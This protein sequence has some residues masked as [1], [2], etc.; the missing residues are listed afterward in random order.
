M[1][2]NAND[3]TGTTLQW[4][5]L[6]LLAGLWVDFVRVFSLEW[7]INEQYAYGYLVP[8]LCLYLLW[9]RWEKQPAVRTVSLRWLWLTLC[10]VAFI[11]LIPVR[12]V[13]EANPDWRLVLWLYAV[14]VFSLSLALLLMWGGW[15]WMLHFAPALALMLFAVPW[16]VNLEER[17]VLGL[18]HGVATVTVEAMNL[19]GIYAEQSGNLIR[20]SSGL[21]G[22]EEACSGVR[23][24]QSTLMAGY[25]LG[26][27]LRFSLGWRTALLLMGACVS[28]VLNIG[29]TFALTY[30]THQR[31]P[32]YMESVH[33]SVGHVVSL[34]AFV[35]LLILAL[36]IKK[37]LHDE[38]ED[39]ATLQ[40]ANPLP[41]LRWLKMPLISTGICL[42]VGGLALNIAWYAIKEPTKSQRL[43]ATVDWEQAGAEMEFEE[44]SPAIRAALR[45][46]EGV[47]SV[48]ET[49]VKEDWIVYFFRW[50]GG[51]ISSFAGVHRPETCL[52]AAGFSPGKIG[53]PLIFQ[54][55]GLEVKFHSQ[56]FHF[57]EENFYVFYAVW[58]DYPEV[59]VPLA[60]TWGDRINL[61]LEGKRVV[62]RR[63]MEIIIHESPSLEIARLRAAEFLNKALVVQQG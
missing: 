15:R 11:C 39:R 25:F 5:N 48:W 46:T 1:T 43:L 60:R 28:L 3:S 47:K 42:M 35:I 40:S 27:M 33:D 54:R 63:S 18:M 55:N 31:G 13:L 29:R 51:K 32:E 38:V 49:P 61:A 22:V 17:L 59:D 16:P 21:V 19:M 7:S 34:V 44:I 52:P 2:S 37:W 53:E 8:F 10:V 62:G 36:G 26:E 24:F 14:L 58:D 57:G 9:T 41:Q 50:E 30:I 20:L 4:L 23:S 56:I 12:I 6:A 45:Y